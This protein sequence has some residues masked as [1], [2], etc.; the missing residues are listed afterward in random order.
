MR[1]VGY[2]CIE[3]DLVVDGDAKQRSKLWR[4]KC[5]CT[6][7]R[8]NDA[9]SG[10]CTQ[11][12]SAGARAAGGLRILLRG[13]R[14]LRR[15]S[16][17]AEARELLIFGHLI[18]VFGQHFGDAEALLIDGD[19]CLAARHQKAGD[20]DHVGEAGVGRLDHNHARAG[21]RVGF[22]LV[23]GGGGRQGL[24]DEHRRRQRS[25]CESL[26]HE[27]LN[28][29]WSGI[30]RRSRRRPHRERSDAVFRTAMGRTLSWR[31][32]P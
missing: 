9:T 18:A 7:G 2:F 1:A 31:F 20:A 15:S 12:N 29:V 25:E 5:A 26:E 30:A 28:H 10:R 8:L 3:L 6:C 23:L 27:G 21:G 17:A 14:G 16:R 19:H 22:F 4:G 13:L 24:R 11:R 32:G